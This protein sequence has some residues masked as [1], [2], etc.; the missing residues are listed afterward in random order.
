MKKQIMMES[1]NMA[2]YKFGFD[3]KFSYL[4][5]PNLFSNIGCL[6]N[7]NVPCTSNDLTS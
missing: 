4:V 3:F 6:V 5:Y 2:R 1:E 7:V